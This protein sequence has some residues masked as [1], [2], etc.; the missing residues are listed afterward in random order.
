MELKLCESDHRFMNIIW[1]NEPIP[2][3]TL[4]E[5]CAE[6]LGWKK[7]TTYTTLRKLCQKGVAVNESSVVRA[8]VPREAVQLYESAHVV[9]RSFSG[10]LP[11]FIAAFTSVRPLTDDEV[12]E[13]QTL[14]SQ[15][16]EAGHHEH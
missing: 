8:L 6:I 7:S 11:A 1:D 15:S 12:Q 3:G 4:V 13:I 9:D 5:K 2:S 16:R 10:S 14:I